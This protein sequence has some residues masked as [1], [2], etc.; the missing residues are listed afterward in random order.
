MPCY[1]QEEQRE[2]LRLYH[3]A[4]RDARRQV[5]EYLATDKSFTNVMGRAK[6]M[7][8]EAACGLIF[9]FPELRVAPADLIEEGE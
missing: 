4:Y 5:K 3:E 8:G 1:S 6:S 7:W 2:V 9:N